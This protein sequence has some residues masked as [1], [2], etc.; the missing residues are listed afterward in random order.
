[1]ATV[2]V[3]KHIAVISKFLSIKIVIKNKRD[4]DS[5]YCGFTLRELLSF[6]TIFVVVWIKKKM[7]IV[8]NILQG[9][10]KT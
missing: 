4:I 2:T 5:K 6:F 9:F 3:S 8:C 10:F 7:V 1:M